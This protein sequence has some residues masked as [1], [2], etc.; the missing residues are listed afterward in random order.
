MPVLLLTKPFINGRDKTKIYNIFIL[1]YFQLAM[2][3]NL[4]DTSKNCFEFG[5]TN[6]PFYEHPSNQILCIDYLLPISRCLRHKVVLQVY[7]HMNTINWWWYNN[8]HNPFHIPVHNFTISIQ[9][10]FYI[11]MIFFFHCLNLLSHNR[12]EFPWGR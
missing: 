10:N 3:I 4:N 9:H 1:L 12:P 2:L 5:M 7:F 11:A 6:S 8:F